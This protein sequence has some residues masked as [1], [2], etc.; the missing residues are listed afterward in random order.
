MADGPG[1]LARL[2]PSA[3]RC[4]PG[5]PSAA[6]RR[7]SL[8]TGTRSGCSTAAAWMP[9]IASTG[10]TRRGR[11]VAS[12]KVPHWP[13]ALAVGRR[14]V[15]VVS[16]PRSSW[17]GGHPDRQTDGLAVTRRIPRSWIPAAVAVAGGAVWVADPGVAALIRID[18]HT[19]GTTTRVTFPLG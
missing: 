2:D 19:L 17:W 5:L 4:R 15:W 18:P 11:V 3:A 14:Y 6:G 10:W 16:S 12:V 8:R 9:R 7:R 1:I 13:A